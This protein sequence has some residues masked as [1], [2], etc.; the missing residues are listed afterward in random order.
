M[1]PT[2]DEQ[3]TTEM[4]SMELFTPHEGARVYDWSAP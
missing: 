2:R 1:V 3:P 4:R